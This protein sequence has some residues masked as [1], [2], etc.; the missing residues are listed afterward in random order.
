MPFILQV[1]IVLA[2]IALG[3]FVGIMLYFP[4][5]F[6]EG[7]LLFTVSPLIDL[8]TADPIFE[9]MF[10][11]W[12]LWIALLGLLFWQVRQ[13]TF[14]I[15]AFAFLCALPVS[16]AVANNILQKQFEQNHVR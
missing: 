11:V 7:S 10:A 13:S 14:A 9:F 15:F 1:L 4:M 3:L 8:K 5:S 12:L 2:G 16:T 6:L